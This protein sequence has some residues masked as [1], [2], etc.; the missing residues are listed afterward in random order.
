MN[1]LSTA[2]G[3]TL[4]GISAVSVILSGVLFW[5]LLAAHEAIGFERENCNTRIMDGVAQAERVLRNATEAAEAEEI[6]RRQIIIDRQLERIAELETR[7]AQVASLEGRVT[8]LIREA[9]RNDEF[10][11]MDRERPRSVVDGL[12]AYEDCR[13]A[14]SGSGESVSAAACESG[15]I[16]GLPDT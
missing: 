8:Q 1:I 3:K 4:L 9:E 5:R 6:L 14:R 10:S 2:V 16:S 12:R 7:D 13:K 15:I 11:C